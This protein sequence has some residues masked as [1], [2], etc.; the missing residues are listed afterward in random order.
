[1]MVDDQGQVSDSI[2]KVEIVPPTNNP[3]IRRRLAYSIDSATVMRA[4]V[5]YWTIAPNFVSDMLAELLARPDSFLCVD[6]H[7]PTDVDQLDP[8]AKDG[9]NIW[10][11]LR[12][13]GSRTEIQ[14]K[15]IPEHLMHAK[16]L[17]FDML[18][19]K[20]ELWSGSHNWTQRALVGPNLEASVVLTIQ[21]N[22]SI[23]R[24]AR[25]A[26]DSIRSYCSPYSSE[27]RGYYKLLQG[28]SVEGVVRVISLQGYDVANLRGCLRIHFFSPS[29]KVSHHS[30]Y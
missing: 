9:A 20:A 22:S 19:G 1:M 27:L 23:Y 12:E 25:A 16:L 7:Y 21:Q 4:A 24:Q 15:G 8:L 13:L 30:L 6:I 18:D 28:A 3:D 17:L 10:L 5:A 26:L 2:L 11:H 29:S 14:N